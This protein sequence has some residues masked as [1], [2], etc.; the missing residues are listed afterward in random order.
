MPWKSTRLAT[1]GPKPQVRPTFRIVT[2]TSASSPGD[3]GTSRAEDNPENKSITELEYLAAARA[4]KPQL[5][6]LLADD[7]PWSSSLRDAEQQKDDGKQIRYLRNRLK[8]ERWAAFFK[9]PDDLAKQVLKSV[10][11]L[12][13]TKRVESMEAINQIGATEFGPSF[14]PK[15]QEQIEKQGS[16]EFVILRL[17]PTPWWNT[18]LHLAAALGSD[19]TEILQFVLVDAEGRFLTMAPPTEIRRALAK[20]LPK[21]E[22]V[23]LQSR[24]QPRNPQIRGQCCKFVVEAKVCVDDR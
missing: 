23:Y 17:G 5:I 19:F 21:L 2:S 9:S 20:A 16:A 1:I 24:D 4:K 22:M 14:L 12:E 13:S 3:T 18:R 6:F 11:Q 15:I 10:F 8:A 7:A